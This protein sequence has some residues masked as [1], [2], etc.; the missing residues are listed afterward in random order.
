MGPG[1]RDLPPA[2]RGVD[3]EVD[4]VEL[5]LRDGVRD[6]LLVHGRR[7]RAELDGAVGDAVGQ[8]VGLQHDREG[9]VVRGRELLGVRLDEFL[10][11]DLEAALRAAQLAGRLTRRA[12]TVREVVEDLLT[13]VLAR[14][15]NL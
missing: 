7:L 11:V 14:G 1:S 15:K 12:V 10:L 13:R 9:E 3:V 2:V 5:Q 8:R 6:A 4:V